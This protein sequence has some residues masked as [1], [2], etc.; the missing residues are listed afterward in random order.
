MNINESE[1]KCL[2]ELAEAYSSPEHCVLF[3]LHFTNYTGLNL[4]QVRRAVRSLA[5]KGLAEHSAA[6]DCDDGLMVGSGY[7]LTAAG[8]EFVKTTQTIG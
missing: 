2:K 6:Y 3:F 5:R 1:R 4:T 8:A 7:I